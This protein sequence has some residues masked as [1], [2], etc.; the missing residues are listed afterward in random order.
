M[1]LCD[2]DTAVIMWFICSTAAAA[3]KQLEGPSDL[4]QTSSTVLEQ[5][6]LIMSSPPTPASTGKHIICSMPWGV[7]RHTVTFLHI[8]CITGNFCRVKFVKITK[9]LMKC[10]ALICMPARACLSSPKIK[11]KHSIHKHLA[12]ENCPVCD[13]T[14][15]YAAGTI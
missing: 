7:A 15:S 10:M 9:N 1:C 14:I 2:H 5:S 6:P 3:V 13:H 4:P 8:H 12:H 11:L